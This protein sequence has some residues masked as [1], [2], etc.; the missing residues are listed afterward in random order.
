MGRQV[1]AGKYQSMVTPHV[2][3]DCVDSVGYEHALSSLKSCSQHMDV[4]D[5]HACVCTY[6]C[7]YICYSYQLREFVERIC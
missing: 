6:T 7:M 2:A 1:C 3:V 5:I 4:H